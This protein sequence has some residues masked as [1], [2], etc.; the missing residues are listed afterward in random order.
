MQVNYYLD[1]YLAEKEL[2]LNYLSYNRTRPVHLTQLSGDYLLGHL[3]ESFDLS[4]GRFQVYNQFGE[5]YADNCLKS[6]LDS[7]FV[8]IITNDQPKVLTEELMYKNGS[9]ILLKQLLQRGYHLLAYRQEIMSSWLVRDIDWLTTRTL[10]EITYPTQW[11]DQLTRD[12]TI[13]LYDSSTLVFEKIKTI[14]QDTIE[15]SLRFEIINKKGDVIL[16][17]IPK[18]ALVETMYYL[19]N[20]GNR[21]EVRTLALDPIEIHSGN[22]LDTN[23]VYNCYQQSDRYFVNHIEGIATEIE[24]VTINPERLMGE[25]QFYDDTRYAP[26]N[27]PIVP[28]DLVSIWYE[29]GL[30]LPGIEV[31]NLKEKSS[32]QLIL[33]SESNN[34]FIYR[35]DREL[36]YVADLKDFYFS[37][38][39]LKNFNLFIRPESGHDSHETYYILEDSQTGTELK[40]NLTLSDLI[41]YLYQ[42]TF[43]EEEEID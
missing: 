18:E 15:E 17:S 43:G 31:D 34:L 7:V 30:G 24:Q 19:L 39:K 5:L 16:T 26:I 1:Q 9:A 27:Y 25:Y 36:E 22:F 10:A 14:S 38:G 33:L 37:N 35:V 23:L 12:D 2:S 42:L 11:F 3:K 8:D 28:E 40:S 41:C 4:E 21:H 32:Q 13:D 6:E 29:K 20:G